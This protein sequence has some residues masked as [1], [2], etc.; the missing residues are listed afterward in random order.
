MQISIRKKTKKQLHNENFRKFNFD[1]LLETIGKPLEIKRP[2]NV[3][4][5][6]IEPTPELI[7]NKKD[8][9][10]LPQELLDRLN[11]C[12]YTTDKSN[13]ITTQTWY[14]S[15]DVSLI[16]SFGHTSIKKYYQDCIRTCVF[17]M[18]EWRYN[19]N[20]INTQEKLIEIL[21]QIL[22]QIENTYLLHSKSQSL[23]LSLL[24]NINNT[25]IKNYGQF[26]NFYE[27]G[28]HF[29][30]AFKI[31]INKMTY[32]IF[33]TNTNHETTQITEQELFQFI[34]QN[35]TQIQELFN[36]YENESRDRKNEYELA[37]KLNQIKL[38][39]IVIDARGEKKCVT[40]CE[41]IFIKK[42]LKD[43]YRYH[44]C[45]DLVIESSIS[46]EINANENETLQKNL[47][48]LKI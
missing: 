13:F 28:W 31:S 30:N 20:F 29:K 42:P 46:K 47:E 35:Q 36:I 11:K 2:I 17:E 5:P 37:Q 8:T 41:S 40:H 45:K 21:N 26:Q 27:I 10:I 33:L 18:Y 38:N 43:R 16:H 1:K 22:N 24:K 39:N 34:N 44:A 14:I 12:I 3:C 23:S 15:E 9:F 32:N 19:N 48:Q 6:R 25:I 4:G 7:I